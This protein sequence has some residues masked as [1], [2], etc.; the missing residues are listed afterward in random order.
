MKNILSSIP[1]NQRPDTMPLNPFTHDSSELQL[2]RFDL[3]KPMQST[4]STIT[5]GKSKRG[6]TLIELLVVIAIIAILAAMLL[7]ALGRAKFKAKV[8]NCTSNFR[9]WTLVANM[10]AS[11]DSQGRLPTFDASGGGSYAWDVGT[12]MPNALASYQLTVP[13]WFDPVRP[14][15]FEAANKW[16]IANLGHPMSKLEDMEY[17]LSTV[18]GYPGECILNHNYWVPRAQGNVSYPTDWSTKNPSLWPPYIKAGQPTSAQYGWPLKTSDRA[19]AQVPFISDKCG[20]GQAGGL[21]SPSAASSDI[22]NVSPDTAHFYGGKLTGVNAAYADGHVEG[23]N[24]TQVR[25]VYA[26]SGGTTYW[27]Y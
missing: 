5:G 13:M 7:P 24:I 2:A 10:Y 25:C 23:H 11:D 26:T 4:R 16:S 19:A 1:I 27:F 6:F 21:H 8:V 14:A 20:S 9:Q 3:E 15:E 22:N 17:Y 12:N 18:K